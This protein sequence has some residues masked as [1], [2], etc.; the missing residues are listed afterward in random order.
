MAQHSQASIQVNIWHLPIKH[1]LTEAQYHM[2][3]RILVPIYSVD[4]SGKRVSSWCRNSGPVTFMQNG[5]RGNTC[6]QGCRCHSTPK[7]TWRHMCFSNTEKF[8]YPRRNDFYTDWPVLAIVTQEQRCCR[9]SIWLFPKMLSTSQI[10]LHIKYRAKINT[11][12]RSNT[13]M[14]R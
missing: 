3:H 12:M 5:H 11:G 7:R 13:N 8:P 10:K 6:Y 14:Q 9:Q 2:L 4:I 1:P